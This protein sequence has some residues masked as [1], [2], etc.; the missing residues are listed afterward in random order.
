ME[1]DR[2]S[3]MPGENGEEQSERMREFFA[4]D[5]IAHTNF[6]HTKKGSAYPSLD[7]VTAKRVYVVEDEDVLRAV[8]I[9]GL[10]MEG[11]TDFTPF[12]TV[13][14][15]NAKI[16]QQ[17]VDVLVTDINVGGT[18]GIEVVKKTIEVNPDAPI[19]VM[20]GKWTPENIGPFID[21]SVD[22]IVRKNSEFGM[23]SEIIHH[24]ILVAL[25]NAPSK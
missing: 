24:A 25:A 6:N 19:V 1:S 13:A 5:A 22:V 10:E 3:E 18:N 7:E 11:Y 8:L 16:E 4:S 23:I 15:A 2:C 20:T 9:R 17:G 12:R 21:M 14:A